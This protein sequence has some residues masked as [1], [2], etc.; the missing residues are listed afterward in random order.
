MLL[1]GMK[2]VVSDLL[3]MEAVPFPRSKGRAKRRAALGHPQHTV[4]R[5]AVRCNRELG[6]IY[7]H[8]ETYQ[9]LTAK[10]DRLCDDMAER[11]A[12]EARPRVTQFSL[13]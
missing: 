10:L 3:P 2:I 6:E 9:V 7:M 12:A 8:S 13:S 1:N 11:R 4:M 5:R